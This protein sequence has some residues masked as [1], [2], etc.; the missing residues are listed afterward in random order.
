MAIHHI[1]KG[2]SQSRPS[3]LTRAKLAAALGMPT[4]PLGEAVDDKT[5]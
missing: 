4:P 1:K 3:D 2:R 5:K